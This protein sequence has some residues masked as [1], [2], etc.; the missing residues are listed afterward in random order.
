MPQQGQAP[1]AR[2]GLNLTQPNPMTQS[3]TLLPS[4]M[5]SSPAPLSQQ[6]AIQASQR[7]YSSLPDGKEK[8]ITAGAGSRP[9]LDKNNNRQ[10]P[11]NKSWVPTTPTPVN[12][13]A[14]RPTLTGPNSGPMG[15]M[16]QPAIQKQPPFLLQGPGDRVLDKKKLDE[17]VRQVTGGSGEGLH[18][19]VE[20]V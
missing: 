9:D 4:G 20:E 11:L 3:Q 16:G 7:S 8:S 13:A 6:A 15:M 18:T 19:E 2:P 12:M 5:H 1:F 14:A 10:W 17:L